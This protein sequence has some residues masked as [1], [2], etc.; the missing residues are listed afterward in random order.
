MES[1]RKHCLD[2]F[3]THAPQQ[4][5]PHTKL[6][7]WKGLVFA[8]ASGPPV[9][10]L[11]RLWWDLIDE[12]ELFTFT[13][14]ASPSLILNNVLND[15]NRCFYAPTPV[16]ILINAQISGLALQSPQNRS[17]LLKHS[18]RFQL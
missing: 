10:V 9:L 3:I 14:E 2:H 18:F 7:E 1:L 13:L 6:S 12:S 8:A 15:E 16:F 4:I 11:G 17:L 5:S